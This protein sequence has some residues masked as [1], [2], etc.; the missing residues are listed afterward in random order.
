MTTETNEPVAPVIPVAPV[1]P[2][3]IGEAPKVEPV[4]E[5]EGAEDVRVFRDLFDR[6]AGVIDDDFLR[7]D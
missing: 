3:Q 5:P 1:V 4:A 6:V 2:E 7:G